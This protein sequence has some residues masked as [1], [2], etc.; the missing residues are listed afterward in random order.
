[1]EQ[2]PY[3]ISLVDAVVAI[4][5][6]NLRQSWGV[7]R[8]LRSFDWPVQRRLLLVAAAHRF[9]GVA[10]LWPFLGWV[11][12]F[13]LAS[14][15]QPAVI[16][17]DIAHFLL[18]PFG[19][20]A[21]IAYVAAIV[22]ITALEQSSLLTSLR[23]QSTGHQ[24][25]IRTTL[26]YSVLHFWPIARASFRV[27]VTLLLLATPF[28]F[29]AGLA[30][31]SML[32]PHDINFYLDA[33]PPAFWW[34]SITIGCILILMLA[35]LL[36]RLAGLLV[37][38]PLLLFE[39]RPPKRAVAES[40]SLSRGSRWVIAFVLV[41][42]GLLF[43]I[44]FWS[45][46]LLLWQIGR[47]IVPSFRDSVAVLIPVMG[48]L[49]FLW[50]A[51]TLALSVFQSS[52]LAQLTLLLYRHLRRLT[53]AEHGQQTTAPVERDPLQRGRLSRVPTVNGYL[54]PRIGATVTV[55]TLVAYS[56][57]FWLMLHLDER[58]KPALIIAHR[59]ASNQAPQ[60][61]L[62]AFEQAI[63]DGTDMVELDVQETADGQVVVFHD[64]DFMNLAATD[65]KIWDA[66]SERLQ[67]IDIG[68]HFDPAFST[69]RVPTLREALELCRDRTI[70]NI[71]LKYYGH[72]QRLARRVVGLVSEMQMDDQVVYM[73]LKQKA[74]K[75]LKRLRPDATVG[76]LSA[77][78]IGDL[79]GVD[80]D[81]FAVSTRIADRRLIRRV[82]AVDRS[83]FVWTVDEPAVMLQLIAAGVDGVITNSPGLAGEVVGEWEEMSVAERFLV[84]VIGRAGFLPPARQ[85][86]Q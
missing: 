54:V 64:S 57:G 4:A 7:I 37:T 25:A 62:A 69:E 82:H 68:S 22:S 30:G 14:S 15:G 8:S 17:Q 43:S 80:A 12:R 66:T 55:L 26:A 29:A 5:R 35:V 86:P 65:L 85:Q 60:N 1:M 71:E 44:F 39:R 59:G 20:V 42:W 83:I 16:D 49:F 41:L 52:V 56:T 67:D 11:L 3:S 48:I 75:E 72:D 23:G 76:L 32:R 10:V 19:A 70:V 21:A 27:V 18:S 6:E 81:F 50:A 73:S 34:A 58:S 24:L 40:Q 51:G 13:V 47:F 45:Y 78:S 84:H 53:P 79:T 63:A 36:P 77:V 9:V 74:V 61:T 28:L 38:L 46:S 33:R 31:W 2:R